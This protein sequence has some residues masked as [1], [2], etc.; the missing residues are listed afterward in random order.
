MPPPVS[1]VASALVSQPPLD[2]RA[3]AYV[4]FGSYLSHVICLG[5]LYTFTLYVI[6]FQ[7]SFGIPKS[8]AALPG[9]MACGLML[10]LGPITG[11]LVDKFD[12]RVVE[13]VTGACVAGGLLCSSYAETFSLLI[14]SHLLLG[15]GMSGAPSSISLV[16]VRLQ[17]HHHQ[18]CRRSSVV[19]AS[20]VMNMSGVISN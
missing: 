16:Q 20:V 14:C 5:T 4:V 19:F 9:S 13:A 18:L 1:A 10:A 8:A 12:A 11:R 7:D 3:G 17:A 6:P 15:I 2:S